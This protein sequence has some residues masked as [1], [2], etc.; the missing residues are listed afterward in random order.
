MHPGLTGF[1][2]A[3]SLH[4]QPIRG[5]SV[6]S[7]GVY[8]GSHASGYAR[9]DLLAKGM[10]KDDVQKYLWNSSKVPYEK[11]TSDPLAL[12]QESLDRVEFIPEAVPVS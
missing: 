7:T 12:I 3:Q 8:V 6:V 5:P 9:S 10:S 11:V 1:W 2:T 4:D